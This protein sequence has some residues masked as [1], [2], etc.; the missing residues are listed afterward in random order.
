MKPGT[1]KVVGEHLMAA[2]PLQHEEMWTTD[3]ENEG[4]PS[5][6]AYCRCGWIAA[7]VEF[8]AQISGFINHLL[9]LDND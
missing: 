6:R 2:F 1:M 8:P 5:G 7:P 4:G 9:E 3:M